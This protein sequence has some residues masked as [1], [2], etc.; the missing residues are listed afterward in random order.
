[1][2]DEIV[3]IAWLFINAKQRKLFISSSISAYS[4]DLFSPMLSFWVSTTS[5]FSFFL[6]ECN[7]CEFRY[8][9]LRK[10][11]SGIVLKASGLKILLP[12]LCHNGWYWKRLTTCQFISQ[13]IDSQGIFL[14][15]N[16]IVTVLK[17]RVY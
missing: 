12:S 13:L 7:C 8:V 14:G 16:Y 6:K 4:I 9:F 2:V 17:V 3:M 10:Y 11:A 5:L 1:M 15:V